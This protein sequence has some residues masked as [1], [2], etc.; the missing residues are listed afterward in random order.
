MKNNQH[1]FTV[2]ELL[3]IVIV[4]LTAGGIGAY[5]YKSRQSEPSKKV[6][7]NQT[8]VATPEL[9][10]T[11]STAYVETFYNDYMRLDGSHDATIEFIEKYGTNNLKTYYEANQNGVD[12]IVCAQDVPTSV[13]VSDA[14]KL[15]D[16]VRVKIAE[17]YVDTNVE[18]MA[19]VVNQNGLKIDMIQCQKPLP[20]QSSE[21][22]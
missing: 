2:L 11:S 6:T 15:D 18:I 1:G 8:T 20:T 3:L 9:T 13:T 5:V 7:T 4:L 22:N 12:P 21:G 16:L 19:N 17:R 14:V 10:E